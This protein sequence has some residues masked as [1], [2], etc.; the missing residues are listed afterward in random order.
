VFHA[1]FFTTDYT[2]YT[3]DFPLGIFP[4]RA[5]NRTCRTKTLAK[6]VITPFNRSVPTVLIAP[7]KF[8]GT[9]TAR[10]AAQAIARGWRRAHPKHTLL[11][12]PVSD[13]GD[14][15]G[16]VMGTLLNARRRVVRT[17]NAAHQP[18][19]ATWW[20]EPKSR[21]AIIES[22]NV[23]GLAMLPTRKFHPFALDTFGLGA[24]IGLAARRGARRCLIGLGGSA[25]NDG[26]FGLARSLGWQ[27]F[28]R[29][30]AMIEHWTGLATLAE[31][32]APTVRGRRPRLVAAVDVT[33]PLSGARGATRTYG[34]QKGLRAAD[35]KLAERCLARLALVF[36]KQF[37]R[38]V[39]RIAGAGAAGG[40]GF[41]LLAFCGATIEPGF[42]LVARES[43]LDKRLRESDIV[44][45]GEGRIDASTFM[46]KAAGEIAKRCRQQ[47][48]PC[49][50]LGGMIRRNSIPARTFTRTFALTDV[51]TPAEAKRNAKQWLERLAQKAASP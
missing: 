26:G 16:E 31:I 51:T 7:D 36:K 9:L 46:G 6:S 35:L 32:R 39:S 21:T 25:T 42:S 1:G 44:V 12:L 10:E 22:A 5:S 8:K 48:T 30:G 50:A 18:I 14:G 2:D 49:I 4:V 29:A 23:I 38:D 24:A 13:G 47:K 27:F 11:S 33:N 37:G 15:F 20:W 3:D 28:D 19:R 41:G 45:T 17:V 40:L 43:R 34:P